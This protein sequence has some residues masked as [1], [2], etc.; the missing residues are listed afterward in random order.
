MNVKDLRIDDMVMVKAFQYAD[1]PFVVQSIDDD[2]YV[3]LYNANEGRC[4]V[5]VSSIQGYKATKTFLSKLGAWYD[6]A[7]VE[8]IFTFKGGLRIAIRPK[9]G[10]ENYTAARIG[11]YK[12]KFCNFTYI[13]QLQHWLWDIYKV[14]IKY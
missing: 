12:P 13:H 3:T 11:E 1:K 10:T 2:N 9:I 5:D 14:E 7:K 6:D 4:Q 8:H